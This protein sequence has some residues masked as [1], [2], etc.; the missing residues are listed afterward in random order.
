MVT[1]AATI[2][3]IRPSDEPDLTAV[4][5]RQQGA[6]SSGDYAIVGTTLQIVGESLCEA[7]DIRSGQKVL[8]VAAGNGNA[9]LA[10]ARRWCDVVSTDYVPALLD[11]ARERVA[12]ERLNVTF[13]TADAEALP[14]EDDSFD[15]VVSTF[16]VMFTP[17]QERAAA[18]LM[19]VC[20]PGGKIGLA[21][22]TPEGFIGQLFKTIGKHLPPPAG[23][24]SPALW[25]T[26]AHLADL[27]GAKAASIKTEVAD[28]RVPLPLAG[29]LAGDLHQILRAAAQGLCGARA[30]R[31]IGAERR[32]H[33]AHR[34]LQPRRRRHGGGAGRV[35]GDRHHQAVTPGA[36][37]TRMDHVMNEIP[38]TIGAAAPVVDV[39]DVGSGPP[40][41]LVHSASTGNWQWRRLIDDMGARRRA[42]AVNLYG[43]GKTPAWPEGR[44]QSLDAQAALVE[45]AAAKTS[46]PIALIGHSFGGAV[47]MKAALHLADR[48]AALV[49]IEPNP[50][51]L[52]AQHRRA[53]AFVEISRLHALTKARGG[54][55]GWDHAG[56][57]FADYWGG[58]GSWDAM[59]AERR[60]A[61]LASF[62]NTF[63]EWDGVMTDGTPVAAYRSLAARTLLMVAEGTKRPIRE[64][65]EILVENLP[66]LHVAP[67]GKGGHMAPLSNPA[68]VNPRVLA[69]LD[70]M[71]A[72]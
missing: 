7:V 9:T 58:A 32:H 22:W 62:R 70:R 65:G 43:Y 63:Y 14:F 54:S 57:A 42:L 45:A 24:K 37:P 10:A 29:T 13:R 56:A 46:G 53:E 21:N 35:S 15:V 1:S 23:V 33:G 31:A 38:R 49:L 48:V 6:W 47:A 71:Q 26:R 39:L 34:P 16:G 60:Q 61:F 25:G 44:P 59:P 4:K 40:A 51:Y 55:G 3:Q 19:R 17:D 36:P 67:I 41:V 18:E 5:T 8:D 20:R 68:E 52:L 12:A 50:F 64:I 2:S 27:F 11:R 28:L 69:F 30:G 66:G 72:V